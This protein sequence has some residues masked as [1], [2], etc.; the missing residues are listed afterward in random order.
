MRREPVPHEPVP[1][2]PVPREPEVWFATWD[3]GALQAL[4]LRLLGRARVI[5]ARDAHAL[6][7]ARAEV[8]VVVDAQAP[9]IDLVEAAKTLLGKPATTVVW[10]AGP[11]QRHALSALPGTRRWMHVPLETSARELAELLATMLG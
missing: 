11:S 2:E 6:A 10:G 3:L 1:H 7:A 9:G 4:G 5:P 8:L